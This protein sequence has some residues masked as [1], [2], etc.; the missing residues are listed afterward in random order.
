M[1]EEY[2][3][4]VIT[5]DSQYHDIIVKEATKLLD[6]PSLFIDF[7]CGLGV[8]IVNGVGWLHLE[9]VVARLID[10]I[11]DRYKEHNIEIKASC[12]EVIFQ[13]PT[14][15]VRIQT[16]KYFE[17][18]IIRELSA[19]YPVS[20][21]N[22]NRDARHSTYQINID[23]CFPIMMLR[24]LLKKLR[25]IGGNS[26]KTEMIPKGWCSVSESELRAQF[27]EMTNERY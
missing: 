7:D 15:L 14:M 21:I 10:E 12:P 4:T 16:P 2:V 23:G 18:L 22:S 17:S 6:D 11:N 9:I 19:R 24:G 25:S 5:F 27:K 20:K 26:I 8:I 3:K 13:Q 1:K